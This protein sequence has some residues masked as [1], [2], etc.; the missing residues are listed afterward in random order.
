MTM[1]VEMLLIVLL[2]GALAGYLAIHALANLFA[3]SFCLH[4]LLLTRWKRLANKAAIGAVKYGTNLRLLLRMGLY[5]LLFCGLIY[6]GDSFIRKE[7]RFQYNGT[8]LI[9]F[10]AVASVVALSRLQAM[11]KR[12][13][14]IWR[15]S[16][17]F[18]YAERRQRTQRL[19]N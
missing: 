14:V 13:Q 15:M 6:Y 8:G 1:N 3:I 10:A 12:S 9:L 17:T 7:F 19:K 18:D 11:R 4:G 16:H 2:W 5:A